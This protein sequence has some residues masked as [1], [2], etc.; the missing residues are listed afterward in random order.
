[1]DQLLEGVIVLLL[2][3]VKREEIARAVKVDDGVFNL[4]VEQIKGVWLVLQLDHILFIG[5]SLRTK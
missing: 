1:M 4:I 2:F 5:V 3:E